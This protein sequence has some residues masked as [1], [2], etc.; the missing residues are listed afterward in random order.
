[1]AAEHQ[2]FNR[3]YDRSAVGVAGIEIT[4]SALFVDE[5]RRSQPTHSPLPDI[6]PLR[7]ARYTVDDLKSYYTEAAL[8][9]GTPCSRQIHDW[10][11]QSTLLGSELL[12]LRKEWMNSDNDK[13]KRLGERFL[14]PHRWRSQ[15]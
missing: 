6:S 4:D 5:M 12:R 11:W 9:N 10:F 3:K 13:L 15:V 8:A 7:M 1:M 14:V 2:R